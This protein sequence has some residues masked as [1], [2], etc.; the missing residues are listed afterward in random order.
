MQDQLSSIVTC[1]TMARLSPLCN[2]DVADFQL[3]EK[4]GFTFTSYV[5]FCTNS[6]LA[7]MNITN[8]SIHEMDSS[9]SHLENAHQPP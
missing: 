1:E 2:S 6:V 3:T 7:T 9:K 8:F 4:R 5:P